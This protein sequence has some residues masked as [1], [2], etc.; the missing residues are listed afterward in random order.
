MGSVTDI[1]DRAGNKVQHYVYSAFG[2][3]LD[4]RDIAGF[5]VYQKDELGLDDVSQ[6]PITTSFTFTGR[7][8]DFETGFYYL[9]ARYYN[10]A[11]GR[12][13]Q[14]D[15]APGHLETPSTIVNKYIYSGN[16]PIEYSDPNGLDW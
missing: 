1:V 15:P 5:S 13:M 3:L 9:R 12:F 6:A 2:D 16:N 4:I 14:Q 11:I 8:R 10:A 7:E